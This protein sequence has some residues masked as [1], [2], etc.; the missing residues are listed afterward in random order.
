MTQKLN[1]NQIDRLWQHVAASQSR[2]DNRLNFFLIFESILMGVVGMLYSRPSSVKI[3]LILVIILGIFLTLIWQYVQARER[4]LLDDLE[5]KIKEVVP[6]YQETVIRR[7]RIKWPIGST[8][9]LTFGVPPLVGII[10]IL[11][12][13]LVIKS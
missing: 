13:V 9:L 12:I 4:Y 8:I 7:E 10:W 6:E 5:N 2:F 1:D 3:V 11:L